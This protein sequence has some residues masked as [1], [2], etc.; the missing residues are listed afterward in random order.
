MSPRGEEEEDNSSIIHALTCPITLELFVDPV[1]ACDGYTYER[2]AITEWIKN[3]NETSPMTRQ[4]I[5]IKG[6]KPNFIVKQLAD[7]YRLLAKETI[8][9]PLS[10][11]SAGGTLLTDEQKL[12]I[13]RLFTKPKRWSLIYKA[14]R[15]G[16]SAS[17]F[18]RLC[19]DQGTTLTLIQTR[20]RFQTKKHDT[21]FGGYTTIP[22][23]SRNGFYIDSESFIFLFSNNKLTRFN[24]HCPDEIAVSHSPNCGPIFGIDDIHI[25]D[26]AYEHHS[27]FSKF[28]C[29][30]KDTNG[31]GRRTF[32][33]WTHFL[34]NE[35][36][37]Y[38]LLIV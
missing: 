35:I 12:D 37:I 36:E 15:D 4:T 16:F 29:S 33:A 23:S 31:Q 38:G 5:K 25:C 11:F 21:I 13:N 26:R 27:S 19:D 20:H 8:E 9:K 1:V 6:L 10:I 17:D 7:Q 14:S 30:F 24:L 18:H 3:N 32:S 2:T 28:P 34:V 22:W